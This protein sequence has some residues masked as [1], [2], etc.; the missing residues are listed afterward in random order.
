MKSSLKKISLFSLLTFTLFSFTLD[1]STSDKD[2]LSKIIGY[3]KIN[4]QEKLYLHTDKP[5][6]ITGEDLWFSIYL[7]DIVTNLPNQTEKVVY[8]ELINPEGKSV[9]KNLYQIN[10]GR[11][12]GQIEL[13]DTLSTGN[14]LLLA[15][16]NWM[17]NSGHDFYFKKEVV[18]VNE[19]TKSQSQSAFKNSLTTAQNK[20]SSNLTKS[21]ANQSGRISLRF[22]PEGGTIVSGILSKVAFEGVD[23]FGN[24]AKFSG[25]IIDKNG[26]SVTLFQPMWEGK[27][28]FSFFPQSSMQYKA[29][30]NKTDTFDLPPVQSE[31]YQLSIESSF[32]SDKLLLKVQ[33]SANMRGQKV[34]I[35]AMQ[36]QKPMMAFT[37]SLVNNTMLVSIK[38]S[39]LNTGVV[40]FTLFDAQKVP[41]CERLI[42]INHYDFTTINISPDNPNPSSREKITLN[43]STLNPQGQPVP[44][45]FSLAVTDASRISDKY[46]KPLDFVSYNIFGSDIPD[47]NGDASFVMKKSQRSAIQSD[48]VML[49]NGWRRYEWQEV[50]KETVTIPKFLEEPGIYLKGKVM[51]STS[52]EAGPDVQVFMRFNEKDRG[53]RYF[54]RTDENSEFTFLLEDFTDSLVAILTTKNQKE[55]FTDYDVKLESNIE[56]RAFDLKARNQLSDQ[57]YSEEIK[58]EGE[59]VQTGISG[60]KKNTLATELVRAKSQD[61]FVDTTNVSIDEVKILGTKVQDSKGAITSAYGAPAKSVGTKQIEDLAE[62]REWNSGIINVISD[63]FPGLEIYTS[64]DKSGGKEAINFIPRDRKRHRFFVYVDGNMV[65]ASDDK[66]ILKKMLSVYEV[67]DLTSLASSEVESVDLIYPQQGTS[68]FKLNSEALRDAKIEV[69][70]N[71]ELSITDSNLSPETA[72]DITTSE[73]GEITAI[74]PLKDL[75]ENSLFYNSPEAIISIYTKGGGGLYASS[76]IEGVSKIY[77]K[78]YTKVKEFYSPDYSDTKVNVNNDKRS[79]L[80]W[81]P[82]ITT[83]ANGQAQVDF[84]NTDISTLLRAEAVGFSKSGNA[85]NTRIVFGQEKEQNLNM[86][87]ASV[88]ETDN[89]SNEISSAESQEDKSKQKYQVLLSNNQPASYAFVS[90]PYKKWGTISDSNGDF[91]IDDAVVKPEDTLFIS[92]GG[93]ESLSI[94]RSEL[95]NQSRALILKENITIEPEL[96]GEK[97]FIKAIKSILD[98]KLRATEYANSVYRQQ[99]FKG[100]ELQHLLDLKTELKLPNYSDPAIGFSPNPIVGRIFKVENY[101]NDSEFT[102]YNNS[103]YKVPI[104]DVFFKEVTFIKSSYR[105]Y[106]DFNYSGTCTYQNR[107]VYKVTFEQNDKSNWALSSGYALIDAENYG[108]AYINWKH[109]R[110]GSQ[111]IVPDMFLM[112]GTKHHD[113]KLT[114]EENQAF[115][116]FIDGSWKFKGAIQD[117]VFYLNSNT[118]SYKREMLITDYLGE[119]LKSF[120]IHSLT[121]MKTRFILVKEPKYLP[122]LWREA[123]YLPT[124]KVIQKNVPYM[125]EIIFLSQ[126]EK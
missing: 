76:D 4:H 121:D 5:V 25:E 105:N 75:K 104:L 33:G 102:P 64:I 72:P 35:L 60:L 115:Y 52:K 48:L 9:L 99:I 29:I 32:G 84:Y 46:Y 96:N 106:Y 86:A 126:P 95:S 58:Y 65:G 39:E 45:T 108:F 43:I 40:Q 61:F 1:W 69:A 79:T 26:E 28:M 122:H 83:D 109:S 6:Y 2:F 44:G 37:D 117:V 12:S 74:D 92:H 71:T 50:L 36:D 93:N 78:G 42:F 114:N 54:A 98:T 56:S 3:N 59:S 20:K 81:N 21:E 11:G 85:G 103:G 8:V 111:Y 112:G 34:F 57:T 116:Y 24:P 15:Y 13:K 23:E 88:Q 62:A 120:K 38:K 70:Q 63:A 55:K 51:K 90:D 87:N 68:K 53:D 47:Y 19:K 94:I 31:G 82:L 49:T 89:Y 67:E 91:Y 10:E 66:G 41:R 119:T 18:L 14:Y 125:H 124:N 7:N 97:I 101:D 110:K 27:G 100:E 30:I 22:F 107:K 80:Y 17:R 113:F 77:L 123:W 16:T 118:Y 73:T